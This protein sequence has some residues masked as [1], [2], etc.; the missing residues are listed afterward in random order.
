M[1]DEGYIKFQVNWKKG[2]PLASEEIET[3]NYWRQQ[4]FESKLIGAYPD[5]I[6]YGNISCRYKDTNAFIISGSATGNFP[7]LSLQHYSLVTKVDAANNQLWCT[8]PIV[9]S[10]ESMSHSAIYSRCP[11]VMGV[12]HIH[13]LEMWEQLLHQVPTT[14]ASAEYGSP[15]MVISINQLLNTSLQCDQP[16]IFVM[17]G[18]KEGVFAFGHSLEAASTLLLDHFSVV[19]SR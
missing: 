8:G 10:S 5:G 12:V 18:H 3:L 19:K 13:H 16:G 4:L 9:A 7:V 15:E 2:L 6:G 14:D 11:D 17:E 1:H